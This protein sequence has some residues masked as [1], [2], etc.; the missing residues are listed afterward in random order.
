MKKRY[1]GSA[2]NSVLQ[3]SQF[4]QCDHS[5]HGVSADDQIH[6]IHFCLLEANDESKVNPGNN[7]YHFF[8][9]HN[10]QAL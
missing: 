7:A 4:Y 5:D 10:K 8:L 2:A 9:P 6:R 3:K 1:D